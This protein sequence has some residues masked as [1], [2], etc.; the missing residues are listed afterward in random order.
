MNVFCQSGEPRAVSIRETEKEYRSR[1]F[2]LITGPIHSTKRCRVLSESQSL[3]VTCKLYPTPFQEILRLVGITVIPVH[4]RAK[5]F[6]CS[7]APGKCRQDSKALTREVTVST[8]SLH[9][10]QTSSS[11]SSS[12]NSTTIPLGNCPFSSMWSQGVLITYLG[13]LATGLD[14]E[15]RPEKSPYH[16]SLVQMI[17]RW[18]KPGHFPGIL[19][20][21]S[22]REKLSPSSRD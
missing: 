10:S 8:T 7:G 6:Q 20:V 3:R 2:P 4:L 15:A 18:P 1:Q 14:T 13:S 17:G 22:G 12:E 16:T 19:C 5:Y 21:N 11:V 9:S